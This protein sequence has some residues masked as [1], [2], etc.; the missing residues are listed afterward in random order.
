[1]NIKFLNTFRLLKEK[2]NFDVV[3]ANIEKD[4]EFYGTNLW[5]LFFAILIASLGL[6]IDSTAV[7]IG[8]MLISPLM[9]PIVGVGAGL[10]INDVALL[11]KASVNYA[12]AA[13]VGLVASTIYFLLTPIDD[14]HAE[15]LSRTL[16]T[17]YDVLIALFGGFAGI[18]AISSKYKGNVIPGVAIA[19]ALMPPLCTAGY[20]LATWQLQYFLGA[21]YLYLINS[22]FIALATFIT[23]YL[24]KFPK[25]KHED[26]VVEKRERIIIWTV[27]V[28]T[29]IPSIYLAF[30]IVA[31][32]K[33]TEQSN[34]FIDAESNFTNDYLLSRNIDPKKKTITLTY[35][36]QQITEA[37]IADL[38]RKLKYYDL[39][40]VTLEVK[41]G[42][43]FLQEIKQ[44]S[45]YDEK[46]NQIGLALQ[47]NE[48]AREALQRQLDSVSSQQKLV[49]VQIYNELKVQYPQL[50]EA[51][52]QPVLV[53][54]D[55][56]PESYPAYLVLLHIPN[57]LKKDEKEKVEAWLKVRLMNSKITLIVQPGQEPLRGR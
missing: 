4:A 52:I 26:P 32:K 53:N 6:N 38:R 30:N 25:R 16:P 47:K 9:G 31:Q 2:E 54:S 55:S 10:A 19:T 29:L 51:I 15:I 27:I 46:I 43:A 13:G 37:Q 22:V 41:Q 21:F 12:F 33:F 7:V 11:R 44:D 3:R 14:A 42:F 50:T 34:Q 35:G 57:G 56:I 49:S 28:L 40:D 20:G 17:V 36:G 39:T 8:A 24:L 18:I 48:E 5:V 45:K 1:M 23:A